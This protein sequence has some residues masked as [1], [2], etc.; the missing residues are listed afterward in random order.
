LQEK[1]KAARPTNLKRKARFSADAELS[2]KFRTDSDRPR[3]S[4]KHRRTSVDSIV[5]EPSAEEQTET[6]VAAKRG[7][8]CHS[9]AAAAEKRPDFNESGR[10]QK[11][12]IKRSQVSFF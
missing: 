6:S 11:E 4:P 10:K 3:S 2:G 1:T 5:P 8:S 12:F 7:A 9:E